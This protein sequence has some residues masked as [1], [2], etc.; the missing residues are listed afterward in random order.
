M[1]S[2]LSIVS[3]TIDDAPRSNDIERSSVDILYTQER[4][5]RCQHSAC[6]L[7]LS[8]RFQWRVQRTLLA[9]IFSAIYNTTWSHRD[10][11]RTTNYTMCWI[12]CVTIPRTKREVLNQYGRLQSFSASAYSELCLS[13]EEEWWRWRR[14]RRWWWGGGEGRDRSPTR[15]PT[16]LLFRSCLSGLRTNRSP[17]T[18]RLIISFQTIS[19]HIKS[20]GLL[21]RQHSRF[22]PMSTRLPTWAR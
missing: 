7:S 10:R 18:H 14:R 6:R 1:T 22:Y 17:D 19:R 16:W 12:L 2:F 20:T 5:V 11:W 8:R 13:I 9:T 4:N 15:S 21:R 3:V